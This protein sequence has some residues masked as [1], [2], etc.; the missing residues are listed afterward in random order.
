MNK[1]IF[2][3]LLMYCLSSFGQTKY[4]NRVIDINSEGVSGAVVALTN[5]NQQI[6]SQVVTD[7][8]GHFEIEIPTNVEMDSLQMLISHLAY[9]TKKCILTNIICDSV[10]ILEINSN[11]IDGIL[12]LGKKPLYTI[13]KGKTVVDISE[14]K[15]QASDKFTDVLS[16]IPLVD[17]SSDENIKYENKTALV[18]IDGVEQKATGKALT[19]TLKSIPADQIDKIILS[20]NTLGK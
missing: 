4:E 5:L 8:N 18:F 19:A 16:K 10:I 14:V 20:G 15:F 6:F 9:K 1:L 11:Q 3:S 2:I 7:D 12:I 13:E 17:A